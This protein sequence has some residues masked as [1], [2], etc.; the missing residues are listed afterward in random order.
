LDFFKSQPFNE[1][2]YQILFKIT[3]YTS[4]GS[5]ATIGEM[6]KFVTFWSQV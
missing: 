3:F 5:A 2:Y 4:Q 1:N 6:G